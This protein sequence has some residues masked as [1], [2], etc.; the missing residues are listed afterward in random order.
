M[1]TKCCHIKYFKL[2]VYNIISVCQAFSLNYSV[3]VILFGSSTSM[4]H[5]FN[6]QYLFRVN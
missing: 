3:V 1:Q 2:N 6:T 5:I 4:S